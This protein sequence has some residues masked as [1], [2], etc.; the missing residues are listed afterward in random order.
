MRTYIVTARCGHVG[1]NKMIQKKFAVMAE[2]GREAA[3]KARHFPRVL[4]DLKNAIVNV[5][6]VSKE[7]FNLQW[8][9]NDNDNYFLCTSSSMQRSLCSDLHE[10]VEQRFQDIDV[11][12]VEEK[13]ISR[14]K[15]KLK[16]FKCDLQHYSTLEYCY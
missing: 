7:E 9:K 3:Y 1:K 8:E 10:E 13:R 5:K 16:K 14:V 6:E 15:T 4:H 12:Y 2:D 11:T